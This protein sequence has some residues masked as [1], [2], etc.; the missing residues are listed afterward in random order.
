MPNWIVILENNPQL[1]EMNV[2]LES[3]LIKNA[4]L[5]NIESIL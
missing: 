3:V 4:R 2:L 5:E 1:S